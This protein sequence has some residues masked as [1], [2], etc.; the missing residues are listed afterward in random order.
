[1]SVEGYKG[2]W[3]L[4]TYPVVPGLQSPVKTK[5]VG[6]QDALAEYIELGSQ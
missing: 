3:K 1:M 2:G 4:R 6:A 5:Q